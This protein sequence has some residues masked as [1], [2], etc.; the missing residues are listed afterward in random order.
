M[1][2][3]P[4]EMLLP[5][6]LFGQVFILRYTF[7]NCHS[8]LSQ[9]QSDQPSGARSSNKLED[10]IWVHLAESYALNRETSLYLDH[11]GLENKQ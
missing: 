9:H 5:E 1:G 6:N 10:M 4:P 2:Q 3:S 7:V 11:Q 8:H